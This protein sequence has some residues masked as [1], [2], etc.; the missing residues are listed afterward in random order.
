MQNAAGV[1]NVSV[2]AS[3]Q[4]GITSVR[5]RLDGTTYAT[6]TAPDQGQ[7]YVFTFPWDTSDASNGTHVLSAVVTDWLSLDP[8]QDNSCETA[9]IH[10]T[11]GTVPQAYL[12]VLNLHGIEAN[13]T[14]SYS[15]SYDHANQI[16][17]SLSA[18]G[19]QS[20]SL[21]QYEDWLKGR[22]IHVDKPILLTVDDGVQQDLP[23]DALLSQ[24]HM[25][26][27][28]F[29]VTGFADGITPGDEDDNL[30]WR[31][32]RALSSNGNWEIAFHAG[33]FGHGTEYGAGQAIRLG[34]G[35]ALSLSAS[36]PYF[37]SC[38]GTVTSGSGRRAQVRPET[39][40]EM[41]QRIQEEVD[42]GISE[43]RRKVP[44]ADRSAWAAPFND[45]GQWTNL[46]NDPSGQLQAWLPQFLASRFKIVFTETA[47]S[48]Y[49]QATG[50]V[51]GLTDYNRHYRFEIDGDTPDADFQSA[52]TSP[53]FTR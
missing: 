24:Y 44:N 25:K 35:S 19:Y 26:A 22:D 2:F 38:L 12:P 21:G 33:A 45:A 47:P 48:L 42:S 3:A 37:Y 15:L 41:E 9:P 4:Y 7:A 5:L 11:V 46:Y 18:Q 27:V 10:I 30:S 16:L 36:C 6:L 17:S 13:P 52:L 32:I 31:Q 29:V 14:S 53:D 20:V 23:W 49:G 43:L 50:L 40:G 8:S 1:V 51:G 28:L 39:V 34:F